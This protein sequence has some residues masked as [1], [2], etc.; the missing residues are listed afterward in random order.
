MF[1]IFQTIDFKLL[2]MFIKRDIKGIAFCD[3]FEKR[4]RIKND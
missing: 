2:N 4:L 1:V 3:T